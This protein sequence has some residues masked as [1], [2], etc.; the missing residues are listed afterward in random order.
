[1]TMPLAVLSPNLPM[2]VGSDDATSPAY[3]CA[4]YRRQS[5]RWVM[6]DDLLG[7]ADTMR[8]RAE[9][10]LQRMPAELLNEYQDR[11]TVT[12][13][14]NGFGRSV[15]GMAGL[16]LRT[17][18]T[19]PKNTPDILLKDWENI[20]GAGTAGDVFARQVMEKALAKGHTFILTEYPEVRNP[21]GVTKQTEKAALLRPYWVHVY[22]EQVVSWRTMQVGG[23]TLLQQVVIELPTIE[24]KGEFGEESICRYKRFLQVGI[25]LVGWELYEPVTGTDGKPDSTR[26]E[27]TSS[28]FLANVTRIPLSCVYAGTKLGFFETQPPLLD[29]AFTN[30]AH[31]QVGSDHR[32]S[33]HRAAIPVACFIGRDTAVREVQ[34]GPNTGYDFNIGGSAFYLEH[35]G[36]GLGH[37]R[38]H[39]QDLRTDMASQGLAMLQRQTRASETAQAHRIDK[40]EQDSALAVAA[41]ALEDSIDQNWQYHC[42]FRKLEPIAIELNVDYEDLSMDPATVTAYSTMVK[43][44]QLSLDTFWAMLATAGALPKDFDVQ[45]EKDRIAEALAFGAPPEPAVPTDGGSPPPPKPGEVPPPPPKPGEPAPVPPLKK[46]A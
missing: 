27:V 10:Y 9:V 46:A 22:P 4:A 29:L 8:S 3:R 24:A 1:M 39:L 11:L 20:D 30:V 36:S 25:D 35:S 42:Q 38:S 19:F 33:M 14:Y 34:Q 31:Y 40:F 21:A 32:Y 41:R 13:F 16:V 12:E 18:P 23:V 26:Y 37:I 5:P 28:G 45:A 2:P 7:S 44:N 43:D 6:M 15:K 17:P